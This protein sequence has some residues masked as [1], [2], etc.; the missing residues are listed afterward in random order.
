MK[1]YRN[2]AGAE[3]PREEYIV[4]RL[5][6]LVKRDDRPIVITI[7]VQD[8]TGSVRLVI[9]CHT[10]GEYSGTCRL[11]EDLHFIDSLVLDRE[12]VDEHGNVEMIFDT[13]DHP[14]FG[15]LYVMRGAVH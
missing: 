11:L 14:Q 10:K 2:T 9:A 15:A 4:E 7:G 8:S 3:L 12:V 13:A 1:L 6:R 5:E